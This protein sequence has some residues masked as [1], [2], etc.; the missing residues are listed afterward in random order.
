[1]ASALGVSE[2]ELEGLAIVQRLAGARR[3][4]GV[5]TRPHSRALTDNMRLCLLAVPSRS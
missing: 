1:M 4:S 3:G 2:S 5:A